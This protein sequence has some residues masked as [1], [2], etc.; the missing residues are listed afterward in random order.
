MSVSKDRLGEIQEMFF[1]SERSWRT[2]ETGRFTKSVVFW[3]AALRV[4]RARPVENP[5]LQL[6]LVQFI[7]KKLDEASENLMSD[8]LKALEEL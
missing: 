1:E 7:E 8:V 3:L 6:S 2:D 4:V 5:D